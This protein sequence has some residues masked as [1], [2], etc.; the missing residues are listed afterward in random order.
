MSES[1]SQTE[2]DFEKKLE[3]EIEKSAEEWGDK[4]GKE[5]EEKVEK[6]VPRFVEPLAGVIF[7]FIFLILFNTYYSR[8]TFL[9]PDFTELVGFFNFVIIAGIALDFMRIFLNTKGFKL[10]S[11]I[12]KTLLSIIL[13]YFLWIIYPFDTSVFS[14][15]ELWDKII[16]FLIVISPILSLLG[17]LDGLYKYSKKD[18]TDE[19]SS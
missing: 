6:A 16:K 9:T 3:D 11:D 14:N 5:I 7:G 4:L 1:K 12:L 13:S 15:P 10:L 8:L 17:V 19:V 2:K 18:E